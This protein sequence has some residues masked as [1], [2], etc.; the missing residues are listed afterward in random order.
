MA[1]D[2][3]EYHAFWDYSFTGLGSIGQ[4]TLL[5]S[6]PTHTGSPVGVDFYEM[7]RRNIESG[8]TYDYGPYGVLIPLVEY[9]GTGFFL[10]NDAVSPSHNQETMNMEH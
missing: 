9:E 5:V 1:T 4:Y 10:C 6:A 3:E 7:R 8:I 2:F